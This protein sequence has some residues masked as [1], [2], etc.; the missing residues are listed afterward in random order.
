MRH[1]HG[2]LVTLL[3]I[4]TAL[5]NDGRTAQLWQTDTVIDLAH[6]VGVGVHHVLRPI[7]CLVEHGLVYA[8]TLRAMEQPLLAEL[9][10]NLRVRNAAGGSAVF[11]PRDHEAEKVVTHPADHAIALTR[12][13]WCRRREKKALHRLGR[14]VSDK[15]RQVST[16]TMSH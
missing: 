8:R 16:E 11:G 14:G 12:E 4:V 9:V 10:T 7:K 15:Q 5:H 13:P 3:F 1:M 6:A 2:A